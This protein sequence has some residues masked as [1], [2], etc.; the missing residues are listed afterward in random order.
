MNNEA[1][2]EL[3]KLVIVEAC[4]ATCSPIVLIESK[5]DEWAEKYYKQVI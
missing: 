3:K 1:I 5:V 4:K 2:R